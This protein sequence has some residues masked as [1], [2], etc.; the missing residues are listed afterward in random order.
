MYATT[1]LKHFPGEGAVPSAVWPAAWGLAGAFVYAATRLISAVLGEAAATP[2]AVKRAWAEFVIAL[3]F[4]PVAAA[5]MTPPLLVRFGA[6]ANMA[7]IAL[8]IG[9][10]GNLIWPAAIQWPALRKILAHWLNEIASA[11]SKDPPK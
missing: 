1:S 2:R 9:L 3:V 8:V 6:H 4:G 11:I 7:S 10:S 5:A